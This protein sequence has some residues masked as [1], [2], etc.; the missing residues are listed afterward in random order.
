M[1]RE[2]RNYKH[3]LKGHKVY[4]LWRNI[5][6]RCYNEN[7]PSYERYGARGIRMCD[8]WINDMKSFYDYV[9]SLSHYDEEGLTIDR[10]RNNEG[11]KPGNLRWSTLHVQNANQRIQKS[12]TTGFAGVCPKTGKYD[13]Y[14]A[15]IGSTYIS[16]HDII[17][18]AAEARNNYIIK[19]GLFEY[20]VQNT[21][22]A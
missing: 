5:K 18:Q 4:N 16:T 10:I 3:G 20:P 6:E 19:H 11:Y 15:T 9:I 22:V 8:E 12:N 13:Y 7:N 1:K 2:P 14:V 21:L 17:I